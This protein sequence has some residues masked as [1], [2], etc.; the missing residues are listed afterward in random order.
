M[1]FTF[2]DSVY[3]KIHHPEY[4]RRP[5]QRV[6]HL[7]DTSLVEPPGNRTIPRVSTAHATHAARPRE[8]MTGRIHTITSD[9]ANGS[10]KECA[11][12]SAT[13]TSEPTLPPKLYPQ[14]GA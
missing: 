2:P 10:A 8:G 14:R 3:V 9:L 1:R 4:R 7:N 13:S 6:S 11:S 12:D 5:F